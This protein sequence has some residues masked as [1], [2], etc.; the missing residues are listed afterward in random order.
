MAIGLIAYIFKYKVTFN[1]RNKAEMRIS[2]D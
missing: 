2:E 1:F